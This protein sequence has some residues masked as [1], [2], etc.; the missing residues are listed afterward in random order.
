ML[1]FF[2]NHIIAIKLETPN[3]ALISDLFSTSLLPYDLHP[4]VA[5]L[6]IK[7]KKNMVTASYVSPIMRELHN[8]YVTLYHCVQ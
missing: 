1:Y 7:H 3:A 4:T 6:C 5:E 2:I 8:R